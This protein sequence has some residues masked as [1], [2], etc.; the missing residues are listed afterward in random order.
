MQK[1]PRTDPPSDKLTPGKKDE[2]NS[3][4]SEEDHAAKESNNGYVRTGK[5]PLRTSASMST[6]GLAVVPALQKK[7]FLGKKKFLNLTRKYFLS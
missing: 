7:N 1:E 3:R 6:T 2:D 5:S 4:M